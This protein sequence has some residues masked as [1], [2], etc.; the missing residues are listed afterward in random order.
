[1]H[2]PFQP[3]FVHQ[4]L[5]VCDEHGIWY[6]AQVRRID[7]KERL[8]TLRV[9]G[10]RGSYTMITKSEQTAPYLSMARPFPSCTPEGKYVKDWEKV[11]PPRIRVGEPIVVLDD[12]FNWERA[13]IGVLVPVP[14]KPSLKLI[15]VEYEG[16]SLD[17]W[18]Y[19]NSKR[20]AERHRG[21][22]HD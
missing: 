12:R 14:G 2:Y 8:L 11:S 10:P 4:W 22:W 19:S 13:V 3:H 20:I 21:H 15:Q 16:C 9:L 6:E 5:D 18:I 1:M 17:E 7:E